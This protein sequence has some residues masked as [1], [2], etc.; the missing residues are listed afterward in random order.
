MAPFRKKPDLDS[1]LIHK[2]KTILI[3]DNE[4]I[5]RDLCKRALDDY[6]LLEACD[7]VEALEIFEKGGV[8]LI[9]TDV[10]MPRMGGIELLRRLKEIEPTIVVVVMT[11]FADKEVILDALKADAD[12]FIAKPVN[13]LQLKTTIEKSLVK[14]ALKE[15]VANLKSIDRFKTNFLSIVSHKF[16][17]PITSISLFL[18]NITGGVYDP[19]DETFRHNVSLVYEES[20]YLE[21]LVAD[22]LAFSRVM[23]AAEGL[24]PEPC[25]LNRVI[26]LIF[27][28]SQAVA[29]KPGIKTSF[30]MDEL[31][32]LMLDKEKIAF[33]IRQ[34][35]DNAYKFSGEDGTVSVSL[36]KGTA[37]YRIVVEDTGI[38]IAKENL[39]KV[40]EK[41]YQV[42]ASLSG[43][44]KGFGLGLY[45]AKEFIRLHGGNIAIDSK[46]GRGT[47]VTITLPSQKS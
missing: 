37:S 22:L 45:Y 4:A 43:Q 17:T 44:V 31:P 6:R 9:L 25:E 35:I 39:P 36:K 47:R 19:E 10:R 3:V 16:R 46:P 13:L 33:A 14:K 38:G 32:P 12:D 1:G 29:D 11:G 21:Q 18:Q 15:E 20:R 41:F 7:G 2:Q 5:I 30:D 40:F 27:T 24:K 34:V 26:P 28:E 42:D 23:D 8:D